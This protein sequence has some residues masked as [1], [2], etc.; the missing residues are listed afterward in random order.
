MN[1]SAIIA[2]WRRTYV[3]TPP[4]GFMLRQQHPDAWLRVHTLPLGKRLPSTESERDT[5]LSRWNEVA[6]AVLEP[7]ESVGVFVMDAGQTS[8]ADGDPSLLERMAMSRISP[9]P[10]D[11]ARQLDEYM[12]MS[13][14]AL[15]A[16]AIG[17]TATCLDELVLAAALDKMGAVT[18]F[19]TKHGDALCPYDGGIDAV[20][21]DPLRRSVATA[22]GEWLA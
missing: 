14:A 15:W 20:L 1:V 22:F 10:S 21:R 13:A 5:V 7:R 19:S 2:A 8:S 4:I 18:V 6:G 9:F 16:G 12:E 17:W 3:Q 11:W